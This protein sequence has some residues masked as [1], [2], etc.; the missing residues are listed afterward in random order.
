MSRDDEYLRDML[1]AAQRAMDEVAGISQD[2]F[3]HVENLQ[4]IVI[5]KLTVLGEAARRV[6]AQRRV[7]L[8]DVPWG[9]VIAMRNALTHDYDGVNLLEVWQTVQH[10][11]PELIA[12]LEPTVGI[13]VRPDL[14]EG[15]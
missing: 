1:R 9:E 6:S 14:W 5:R 12:L 15:F 11:L 13:K 4:D 8:P 2:T 3:L 10:D 7:A